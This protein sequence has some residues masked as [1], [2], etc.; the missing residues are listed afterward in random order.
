MFCRFF[1]SP[2]SDQ[3]SS[4]SSFEDGDVS[5]SSLT[6]SPQLQKRNTPTTPQNPNCDTPTNL[7]TN[8]TNNNSDASH[9]TQPETPARK[10]SQPQLAYVTSVQRLL[11]AGD[12]SV[13]K[14][15]VANLSGV[16]LN[17]PIERGNT[18][19]HLVAKVGDLG[20]SNLHASIT[21]ALLVYSLTTLSRNWP[22]QSLK[23]TFIRPQCCHWQPFVD[24]KLSIKTLLWK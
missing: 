8:N 19:V 5:S 11:E 21:C 14:R 4:S 17:V 10:L 12:W 24:Q 1:A 20:E 6:D 23:Q 22:R 3:Q 2:E 15:V 13:L 18:I 9:M 7:E 16:D